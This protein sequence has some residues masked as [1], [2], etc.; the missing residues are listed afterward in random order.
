[1]AHH[2][3]WFRVLRC[4]FLTCSWGNHVEALVSLAPAR[5]TMSLNPFSAA[6]VPSPRQLVS[7]GMQ[8]FRRGNV[9]GSIDLFDQADRMVPDGS[10]RPFL[11]QR[12]IS[13]YYADRFQDGSDQ[14][15][16]EKRMNVLSVLGPQRPDY[17]KPHIRA[18][19]S[20]SCLVSIRCQGES[21]GKR[22]GFEASCHSLL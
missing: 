8:A 9:Q 6:T 16:A 11:W 21:F 20:C 2:R 13:Y 3:W 1:M 18:N 7:Q 10:L 17:L 19:R 12:G 5:L 15:S 4:L 22:N 14:V